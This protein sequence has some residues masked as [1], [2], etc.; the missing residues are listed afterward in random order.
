MTTTECG[1]VTAPQGPRP[2]AWDIVILGLSITSSWGNGHATTYRSLA[3][4]LHDRGHR[5]LFLERDVAWYA[6]N[7][8][9]P[10]PPFCRTALYANIAELGRYAAEVRDADLVIVGSFVPDGAE[11]GRWVTRTA[12]GVRA[13]YDI[14]TPI[15]L[16]RLSRG[17]ADYLTRDLVPAY[18]LYLSFTGGPAPER[19]EREFGAPM[20][21]SLYCSADPDCYF[22]EPVQVRWDL[23]YM[24]TY[25][26]D[27]QPTLER[28]LLEPARQWRDGRFAVV[29]PMYPTHL[30]WPPNVWRDQH[31]S[32]RQ[33]RGFYSAQRFTLNVT[34]ADMVA[35]GYSPS[36]RLFEAA[37]CATPIITDGWNGLETIFEPGR[38][39]LVALGT[40]DV[41]AML[42]EL[43]EEERRH[44]GARARERVAREHTA[45]HRAAQLEAYVGAVT[46]RTITR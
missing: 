1:R 28:L 6:E 41:L 17:D 38:E 44:I 16:A 43:S 34:R 8:D 46:K 23:G 22:H 20:A 37:A 12:R 14:D 30:R 3:R 13:F 15:T 42:H 35:L 39:I 5:V 29:G 7:R 4:A 31:L 26:D 11:V 19:L 18:D 9:L 27:R 33:H 21:R 25:S 36:V 32:P 40:N 24:G 45:A 2:E 10:D